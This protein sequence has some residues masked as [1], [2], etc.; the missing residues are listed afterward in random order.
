MIKNLIFDFGKVLVNY[1]YDLFF[2]RS[3]ADNERYLA[4]RRLFDEENIQ[5]QID[6]ESVP[7]DDIL[8]EIASRRPDMAEEIRIFVERYPE[9]VIGE[10]EG[11]K[12]YLAELKGRGFKLYGL[13]NWSTRVYITMS[14]YPV[15]KLLD[16]IVI[17]SEEHLLKPEPEI[18]RR[19][20]DRFGLKPEECL[21]TDDKEENVIGARALGINCLV[22]KDCARYREELEKIIR[23]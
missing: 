22:F 14:Q 17:S 7:F 19:L 8:A 4:F 5:E 2:R 18:Y 3:F 9:I 21:F 23:L 13:T 6:R 12:E 20:L 10:I 16:G 15:F 11:M 1:D